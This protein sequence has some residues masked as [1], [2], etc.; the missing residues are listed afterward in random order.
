MDPKV[1]VMEAI[2]R[3]ESHPQKQNFLVCHGFPAAPGMPRAAPSVLGTMASGKNVFSKIGQRDFQRNVF[4]VVVLVAKKRKSPPPPPS[5]TDR[6]AVGITIP[7]KKTI[8]KV[9]LRPKLAHL[10]VGAS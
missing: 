5:E 10:E 6:K 9:N 4:S 7:T 8:Q 1:A 2:P 3:T